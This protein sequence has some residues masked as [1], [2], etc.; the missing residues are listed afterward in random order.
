MHPVP[1]AHVGDWAAAYK[2]FRDWSLITGRGW[3]GGATKWEN[4]G[5]KTF[6]IP[7]QDRV[8]LLSPSFK[9]WKLFAPP[10]FN[11]ALKLQA[12]AY[13]LPQNLLCPPPPFS[14][15]KT[16]CPPLFRRD[17]ASHAPPLP[18]VAPPSPVICDRSLSEWCSNVLL[19]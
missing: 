14:M 19:T 11:M 12:T 9:E 15:A 3:G 4:H 2:M 17:N 13:K 10:P 8:K 18:F 16:F 6:C 1:I 5:S 7:P